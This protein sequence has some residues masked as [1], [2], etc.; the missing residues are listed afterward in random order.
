MNPIILLGGGGHCKA[1]ID[2]IEKEGQYKIIGIIDMPEK[3][4]QIIS[5]YK[6]I[7]TDD[8]I[9]DLAKQGHNFLITVGHLGD[10]I[11]RVRLYKTVKDNGGLLPVIIS[12]LAYVSKTAIIDEGTI[13]MHHAIV[14]AD[15]RIGENCIINSK[16]LIEHD[17]VI[18]DNTHISTG[19]LIN[20]NCL[21]G[22]NCLVGS[23]AI[24][25][26]TI[27]I[28]KSTIV[29]VGA[30]VTKDI[31]ESGIFVGIPAKKNKIKQK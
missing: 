21:I 9:P 6:V 18:E 4:G 2:V 8:N 29:G 28:C 25:K 31:T 1:C 10:S 11:K 26:H 22:K 20:G 3:K 12:P 17:V 14:N 24:L 30:V 19:A 13:I 27:K 7:G 16:A 15:A 23:G 5:G